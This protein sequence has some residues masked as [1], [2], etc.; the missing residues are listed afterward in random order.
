MKI[1][2]SLLILISSQ[3]FPICKREA[4]HTEVVKIIKNYSRNLQQNKGIE[5][6][7]Y[8]LNHSGPDKIYDGKI[9]EINLG[10]S[11][12]KRMNYKEAREL[13]YSVV[14]GLLDEI[15]K[16]KRTQQYFSHYPIG[17]QDLHIG[18]SFDYS[19]KGHLKKDDVLKIYISENRISYLIVEK[20]DTRP[21]DRY[22]RTDLE[23]E[24]TLATT[25][26][27]DRNLP[28]GADA[29]STE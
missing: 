22:R 21:T 25:R 9:Y 10:Y 17:Y 8:G 14:D 16:N 1:L 5:L 24:H 23:V 11:I 26:T 18:L 4:S 7:L 15:N 28:E 29:A 13:F 2:L 6:K 27:I 12:D 19:G 20:E 3:L